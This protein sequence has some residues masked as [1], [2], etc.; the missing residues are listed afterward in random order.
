M[1]KRGKSRPGVCHEH[2]RSM[3]GAGQE[4]SWPISAP[5]HCFSVS[6]AAAGQEQVRGMSRAGAEREQVRSRA[7]AGAPHQPPY[8]ISSKIGVKHKVERFRHWSVLVGV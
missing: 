5:M 4:H 2:G 3:A 7:G 8:K 1:Q 6:W